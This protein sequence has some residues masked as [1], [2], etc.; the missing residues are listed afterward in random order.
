MPGG[1]RVPKEGATTKKVLP[2]VATSLASSLAAPS[3]MPPQQ[4]EVPE[5]ADNGTGGPANIPAPDHL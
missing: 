3:A 4:I 1:K 2:L 5:R